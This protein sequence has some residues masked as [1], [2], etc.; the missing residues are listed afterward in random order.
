MI[1]ASTSDKKFFFSSLGKTL[2]RYFLQSKKNTIHLYL[3]FIFIIGILIGIVAVIGFH[4][5]VFIPLVASAL[6]LSIM[7]I[8]PPLKLMQLKAEYRRQE[9][10]NLIEP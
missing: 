3:F 7:L 4:P 10:K 8:Y 9:S 2:S 6:P 5:Y 1:L